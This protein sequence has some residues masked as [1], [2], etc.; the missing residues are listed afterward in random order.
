VSATPAL[1][2]AEELEW[3]ARRG[4]LAAGAAFVSAALI[5]ASVSI[6]VSRIGAPEDERETLI[7]FDEHRSDF[8]LSL[9]LQVVSYLLLTVAL[10]YL[11]RATIFRR[12]EMPKFTVGLLLGAPLLLAVGAVLN[13]LELNDVADEFV[14]TVGDRSNKAANDLAEDLLDDRNKLGGGLAQAGTLCLAL[15]FVLVSL[16]AM[17]AGLLSRFMGILGIIVGGLLILPL[18]P[19]GQ[20]VV[21][22]FWLVALGVLF[23]DRWPNGR[24]PAWETGEAVPWPSAAE[25]RADS[26]EEREQVAEDEPLEQD[27]PEDEGARNGSAAPAAPAEQPHPVSKKRKRKKRR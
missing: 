3:E 23:I 15:S 18:L 14:S 17:R 16:N 22:L 25:L 7:L 20:S 5:F 11:F 4:P 12:P 10:F 19:G 2:T 26:A 24:G 21:Q 9:G 13:Q 6:Q 8:M 27:Q 1:S